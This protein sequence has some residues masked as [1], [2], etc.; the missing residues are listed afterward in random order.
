MTMIK[1][2]EQLIYRERMRNLTCSSWRKE[3]SGDFMN[4]YKYLK[5]G[6]KEDRA[7]LFLVMPRNVI[8]CRLA[9]RD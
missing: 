5:G 3:I 1:E 8:N 2:L 6:C 9:L 4:V 7:K